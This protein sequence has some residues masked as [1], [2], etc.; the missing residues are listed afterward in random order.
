[1]NTQK[2]GFTLVELL[3]VI[4]I[5]AVLATTAVIVLN[6]VELLKQARDSQRLSDL[7]SVRSATS[8]YLA[9][10]TSPSFTAGPYSTASTTCAFTSPACTVKAVY[11]TAGSGWAGVDLDSI[12]GEIGRAHV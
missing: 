9:D 2:K 10:V 1:M 11:T 3:I 8:L 6:P 5:L 4:G 7:D 12:T